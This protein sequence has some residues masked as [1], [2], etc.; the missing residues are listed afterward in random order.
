MKAPVPI[1][2]R[3]AEPRHQEFYDI[4]VGGMLSL[5]ITDAE[6]AALMGRILG[7]NSALS[8][9]AT[10]TPEL[11]NVFRWNIRK[12]IEDMQAGTVPDKDA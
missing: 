10:S 2:R 1:T 8:I 11:V 6:A 12:G 3:D 4:V 5:K 9:D 7:Y